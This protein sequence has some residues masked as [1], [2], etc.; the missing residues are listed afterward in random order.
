[1]FGVRAYLLLSAVVA[2]A[3]GACKPAGLKQDAGSDAGALQPD[4]GDDLDV[5]SHPDFALTGERPVFGPEICNNG[6]DDDGDGKVDEGCICKPGAMQDCFPDVARLAGISTCTMGKQPCEGNQEFGGWGK[7]VGAVT[8]AAKLCDGLDNDCDGVVDDGC[9]CEI[10]DKRGCCRG[11]RAR[12]ASARAVTACRCASAAPAASAASGAR[13]TGD[14]LP[15]R[16]L[17]DGL[18]NDCNGTVDDGCACSAGDSR[19][20][21]GGRPGTEALAPCKA[22]R[23]DCITRRGR[24]RVGAVRGA[25]VA[26]AE[27]CDRVDNNC[28]GTVDDGCACTARRDAPLVTPR[29]CSPPPSQATSS[30]QPRCTRP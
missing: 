14:V 17:C 4:A 9:E 30:G 8:P 11:R 22:G 13:A 19:A 18:D 23:Q 25:G 16:D 1:M 10:G 7:C 3:V 5:G 24:L 26:G 21:Y 27:L 12:S 20:C 6:L 15:D 29:C 2:V 28:D